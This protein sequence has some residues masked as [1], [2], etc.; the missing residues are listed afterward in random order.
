M[1]EI[2]FGGDGMGT[3]YERKFKADTEKLAAIEAAFPGSFQTTRMETVYYDTPARSLSARRWTVRRRLENGVSICTVKTPAGN[4]RGEWETEAPDIEQAI[5]SLL[6]LGCPA[7]LE[8][9]AKEGLVPIGGARFTRL[10]KTVRLAGGA[11]ELALDQG[12]LLGGSLE[13]PFCEIEVEL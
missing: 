9:L 3:E 13:I 8:A 4:A 2:F 11:V 7:E 6:A 12:V 5:A 1:R 10:A